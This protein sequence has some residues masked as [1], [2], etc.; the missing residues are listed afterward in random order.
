MKW[1]KKGRKQAWIG[2]LLFGTVLAAVG[3]YTDTVSVSALVH[4]EEGNGMYDAQN[5][6]VTEFSDASFSDVLADSVTNQSDAVFS[7]T[8]A[9]TTV[10][11]PSGGGSGSDQKPA[12]QGPNDQES[13][14]QEPDNQKP[15]GQEPDSQK[16]DNQEKTD[17]IT[18]DCNVF[19][20][21]QE[22]EPESVFSSEPDVDLQ[23]GTESESGQKEGAYI[24]GYSGSG[25]SS[26]GSEKVSEELIRQPKILVESC[27]LSDKILEAGSTESLQVS[28]KNC[29]RS[30]SMYNLKVSIQVNNG[31]LKLKSNSFYYEKVAP[32][33]SIPLVDEVEVALDAE[34]GVVP[35]NLSFEYED[36]KGN[37]AT[38]TETVSLTVSQ[39]VSMELEKAEIPAY[40]YASDTIEIPIAVLNLSR[41]GVYNVRVHLEG[42]GLFPTGDVFIG[43]MEPGSSG[44]GSMKVYVGTKTMETIGVDHGTDD[45]EK[46]GAVSGL[47]TLSYEDAAGNTHETSRDYQTEIKKAQILSL[48]VEE[49]QESGNPWWISV[50]AVLILGMA[51]LI[52]LLFA[53]LRRKNVLLEEARKA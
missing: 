12:D 11:L 34:A 2:L 23:N 10:N 3:E 13:N 5:L 18:V 1:R 16:P 44:D 39:P 27:S 51:V 48:N 14:D 20:H 29:S 52:L 49:D 22:P 30:Q 41:T 50:F 40:V 35:L 19:L 4:A 47:F 9:D 33:E 32:G 46:Y 15:D 42:T 28:L 43:N 6:A 38:G 25:G 24:G 21:I 36:K 45:A 7:D 37:Q 53:G 26:G 31:S 17:P 8:E